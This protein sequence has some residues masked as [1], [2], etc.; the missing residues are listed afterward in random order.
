MTNT[1]RFI[2]LWKKLE[3][4][5]Q[6]YYNEG[7]EFKDGGLA[8][9]LKKDFDSHKVEYC[10]KFRNLVSH[11]LKFFAI[12]PT[13]AM[14]QFLG[15][16]I[17]T[18]ENPPII[19]DI[20]VKEDEIF[21]ARLGNK[22]L[23]IMKEMRDNNYTHVPIIN[24]NKLVIGVF[25]EN[26]VFDY[27]VGNNLLGIEEDA[28]MSA[29]EELIPIQKHKNESFQFIPRNSTLYKVKE[30]FESDFQKR[31]RIG[32]IFATHSGKETEKVLGIITPWDVLG[33]DDNQRNE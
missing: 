14:I 7:K 30:L 21:T 31:K 3:H 1:E 22:V 20:W 6:M 23:P 11:K 13:D 25:S 4:V 9:A 18:L 29:F 15:E 33:K 16:T 32:M 8:Y 28:C 19:S 10:T 24:D 26:T 5:A 12:E 27:L 2:E 17:N